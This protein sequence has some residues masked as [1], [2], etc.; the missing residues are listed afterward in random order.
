MYQINNARL[1]RQVISFVPAPK[2]LATPLDDYGEGY[3]D[4]DD[5]FAGISIG[6]ADVYMHDIDCQW[7]DVTEVP[8]GNYT[9][10]VSFTLKTS[11]I[12]VINVFETTSF[13]LFLNFL[14][15]F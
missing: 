10:K 2:P 9:F 4:Y 13:S 8:R 15:I 7:I 5:P 1:G 3:D 6:C 14:V 12:F 11:C